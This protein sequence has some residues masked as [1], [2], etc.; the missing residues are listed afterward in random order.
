[1]HQ[2]LSREIGRQGYQMATGEP[3]PGKTHQRPALP[4]LG[5]I[6]RRSTRDGGQRLHEI[7]QHRDLSQGEVAKAI[8]V[9]VG[10]IQS[11]E[12]G[13]TRITADRIEQLAQALQCELA[14]LLMPPGSRLPLYR[15]AA[16]SRR[17]RLSA[18]P[19]GGQADGRHGGCP[20][21][22]AHFGTGGLDRPENQ[23]L[24]LAPLRISP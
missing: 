21:R 13:R 15:Q 2:W 5:P 23:T 3:R 16:A 8:G 20:G 24:Q 22:L 12:H 19:A 10:T 11:Y 1:M 9:S 6:L 7:R 17:R 14:D 4:A 18:P